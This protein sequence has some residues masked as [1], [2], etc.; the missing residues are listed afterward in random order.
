MVGHNGYFLIAVGIFLVLLV[1]IV[2]FSYFRFRRAAQDDWEGI[3]SR[4]IP[5]DHDGIEKIARDIV[6]ETGA[7]RTD[8][9]SAILDASQIWA[10]SGG[11]EGLAVL[12]ANCTVLIDLA[13]YVQQRFPEALAITEELRLSAREIAWHVERL[14]GASQTEN[15]ASAFPIYAQQA[16]AAYYSM[17]R[18]VLALYSEQQLPTITQLQKVL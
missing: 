2:G 3:L 1:L 9:N 10:G 15:L 4:L 8:E 12:E 16:V 17:T 6:D 14:K 13:F 11:M 5:L 18:R 7:R